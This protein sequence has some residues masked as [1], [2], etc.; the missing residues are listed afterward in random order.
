MNSTLIAMCVLALIGVGLIVWLKRQARNALLGQREEID[1]DRLRIL[2]GL[3][4]SSSLFNEVFC[5]LGK[6]LGVRPGQLRPSDRFDEIF[7]VDSWQLGE[8][9]D[10]LEELIRAKTQNRPPNMRTIEDL[11]YWLDGEKSS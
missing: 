5:T 2:S 8:A 10:A 7:K 6:G 1:L 4:V 11:L 3:Q 9:Q